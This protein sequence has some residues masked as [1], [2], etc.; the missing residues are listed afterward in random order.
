M[1]RKYALVMLFALIILL[2]LIFT[3]LVK[4][5]SKVET[6]NNVFKEN[7]G[8]V[9]NQGKN[10]LK[11]QEHAY[12]IDKLS[13]SIIRHNFKDNSYNV[14]VN[15]KGRNI[16]DNLFIVNNQLLYSLDNTTYYLGLGDF[17]NQKFT[18]GRV[19]YINNDI[20]LYIIQEDSEECLYITSYDNKNFRRTNSIFSNLAKGNK[21]KYLRESNGLLFFASVNSDKSTSLFSVSL[22]DYKVSLIIKEKTY[23]TD[24]MRG[25]IVDAVRYEDKIYY[26]VAKIANMTEGEH[27]LDYILYEKPINALFN[28]YVK[29][30]LE[31]NLIMDDNKLVIG[32]YDVDSEQYEWSLLY[33]GEEYNDEWITK[34]EGDISKYFEFKDSK[35]YLNNEL[36]AKLD[37][38]YSDFYLN[39]AIYC[40][41][42]LYIFIV[43]DF[44]NICFSLEKGEKKFNKVYE[45][46]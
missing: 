46:R 27:V 14:I 18:D 36:I 43:N 40:G 30:D 37:G 13:S 45:S 28:E 1:K 35:L 24:N 12:I 38:E 11:Y 26:N 16:A 31:P 39:Y 32:N 10:V 2:I 17:N 25:E 9:Y 5:N 44:S 19:V 15:A 7:K 29:S 41:D 21:I 34:I 8:V 33:F 22:E 6:P 42:T 23:T 20:Y 3:F 4:S